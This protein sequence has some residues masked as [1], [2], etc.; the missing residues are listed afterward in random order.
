MKSSA[1]LDV[2]EIATAV[3]SELE[4]RKIAEN[5]HHAA[6]FARQERES[7]RANAEAARLRRADLEQRISI[8][9]AEQTQCHARCLTLESELKSLPGQLLLER[10]K[11][12]VLLGELARLQQQLAAN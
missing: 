7:A 3:V 10:R 12:S 4:Q 1:R 11:Q 2:G 9:E 8:V 5:A 6:E